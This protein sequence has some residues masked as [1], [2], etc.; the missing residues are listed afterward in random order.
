[1][2]TTVVIC[3]A[4]RPEVLAET[5]ES[6][7]GGQSAPPLEIII[8]VFNQTHVTEETRARPGVRVVLSGIQGTCAQRNAA[9]RVVQTPYTLF[10]DD[11]VELA[12]NFIESME[13]L[14]DH[15]TDAVAATGFLVIDGARSARG[16]AGLE[17]SVA[18][19]YAMNYVREHAN[20]DHGEGQNIFVRSQ[21][22]DKVLFDENLPLYGWL[23]DFDFATN[24]L[25][26]GRI[27]MNTE[28]C[29]AHIGT[30][31]GR[32]TGLR[33]GYS[34]VV[35]PFYLWRKNGRPGLARVIFGH[36]LRYLA[37]NCQR[38]LIK[39]PGDRSDRS[40]RF[41]GNMIAL[42]HVLAGKVDP[43]YILQV[44]RPSDTRYAGHGRPR[45]SDV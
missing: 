1:M 45:I 30:P 42:R 5:V 44:S 40:G 23:E 26:F 9:A 17:R 20:Y 31:S 6:V 3:S 36:W 15:A 38:E 28:T 33:F 34:Q 13:R 27:I 25:R 7:L 37:F 8:S 22:F 18:R 29:W 4:N 14:L 41:A 32:T 43:S 12:A 21:V 19:F 16:D 39:H 24:I 10:L 2:K 35:N 11:D